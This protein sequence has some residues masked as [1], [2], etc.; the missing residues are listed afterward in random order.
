MKTKVLIIAMLILSLLAAFTSIAQDRTDSAKQ[1][2]SDETWLTQLKT[3]TKIVT[4]SESVFKEIS[5]KFGEQ[6]KSIHIY[7][8]KDRNGPYKEYV[9][10][11][12][13]DVA[14]TISQWAKN[15]L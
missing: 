10:Y 6:F 1:L 9:I 4:Y 13:Q 8:K 15:N 12:S 14:T 7:Y 5:L 2:I 11:L 3:G